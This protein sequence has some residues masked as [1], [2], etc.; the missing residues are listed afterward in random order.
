MTNLVFYDGFGNILPDQ[1]RGS[2][3]ALRAT[4]ATAFDF[5]SCQRGG[6]LHTDERRTFFLLSVSSHHPRFQLVSCR[7][8]GVPTRRS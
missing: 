7:P 4:Q 6:I 8:D 2:A 5:W 3:A 1:K